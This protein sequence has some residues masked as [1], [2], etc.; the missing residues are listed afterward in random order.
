MSVQRSTTLTDGE[1]MDS[2]NSSASPPKSAHSHSF[3]PLALIYDGK[4]QPKITVACS[5]GAYRHVDATDLDAKE[6]TSKP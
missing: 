1:I 3:V 5:C 2:K 6:T 4:G